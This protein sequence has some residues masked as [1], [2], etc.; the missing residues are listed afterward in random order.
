MVAHS[1]F[2]HAACSD[3]IITIFLL[4]A[5]GVHT[6]EATVACWLVSFCFA[7]ALQVEL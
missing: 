1:Q 6:H 4:V 5:G 7:V 2:E 3:N